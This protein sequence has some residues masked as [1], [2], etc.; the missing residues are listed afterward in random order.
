MGIEPIVRLPH[1]MR[2]GYGLKLSA[3]E[4]LAA[5]GVTL[6]LTVDTGITALRE[7]AAAQ[8]RGMDVIVTDHHHLPAEVPQALALIHPALAPT[9][10]LPHP[11][12]AGVALQLIRALE[13][14]DEWKD[15]ETDF[16][17]AAIGTIADLVP[18][19]GMN[20]TLVQRGL[21]AL[22]GL[23]EGPLALFVQSLPA[24]TSA[25]TSQDIAFRLA[26][27]INAAGRMEDPLTALTALLEG[28][29]AL[30]ALEQLNSNRQDL[31][32]GL[33][34][35]AWQSLGLPVDPR[36]QDLQH[37]PPLLAVSGTDLPEGLIGLIAGKLTEVT[38]HPS[39][40]CAVREGECTGS[41]RSTRAYHITEGLERVSDLL[42]SFGGH[43]QAAGCTFAAGNLEAITQRLSQ[44][45]AVHTT[46]EDLLPTLTIDAIL[47][48]HD[49]TLTFCEQLKHLEPFGQGNPEPLFLVRGISL[50]QR[51]RVGHEGTHLQCRIAGIKTIGWRLGHLI[52]TAAT[53]LDIVCKIGIDSWNG[54]RAPQIVI[55]DA[56]TAQ[57]N[58]QYAKASSETYK[59]L[60]V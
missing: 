45:V 44:D 7:I 52:D 17:L 35:R 21:A 6:L 37:L 24:R 23:T 27:R 46:A 2:D 13:G 48:P 8:E 28:G 42:S 4:E 33:F 22:N 30:A 31:T 60:S 11:S 34:G 56:R 57:E 1:R 59:K 50:E 26:P 51:R 47:S 18:L 25:L 9:H 14:T 19:T 40:V 5:R 58:N 53:P 29:E 43:A 36:A 32:G 49:V 39:L 16:A 55:E 38:G 10:P 54:R 20:R 12:G 3:I 15:H 41:L